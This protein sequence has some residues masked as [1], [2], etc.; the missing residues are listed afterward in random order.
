MAVDASHTS[1][2]EVIDA[3][4]ARFNTRTLDWDALKF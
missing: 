4:I 3:R 2:A 1:L